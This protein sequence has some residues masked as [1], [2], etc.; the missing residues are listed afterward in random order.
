MDLPNSLSYL[1]STQDAFADVYDD[2]YQRVTDVD[3]TTSLITDLSDGLGVFRTRRWDWPFG[4][5]DRPRGIQYQ[6]VDAS[7]EM[8][9]ATLPFETLKCIDDS[10]AC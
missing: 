7:P 8:L 10:Y 4:A 3:G 2:W 1:C 5:A 6:G 9:R